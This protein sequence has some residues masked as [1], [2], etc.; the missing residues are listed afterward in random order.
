PRHEHGGGDATAAVDRRD[1]DG[2]GGRLDVRPRGPVNRCGGDGGGRRRAG[3]RSPCGRGR[4]GGV[5]RVGRDAAG[6]AAPAP[7]GGG[8]PPDGARAR[9]RRGDGRRGGRD[10]RLG[11]V[12][13]RPRVADAAR[14]GGA[15][16]QRDR[17]GQPP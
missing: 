6:R 4:G 5:P 14:G 1:V 7:V 9:D 8:G 16:V 17:A 2:R 15:D 12:Q 10:V 11:D 3:G 13:L